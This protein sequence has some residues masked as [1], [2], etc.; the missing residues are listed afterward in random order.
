MLQGDDEVCSTQCDMYYAMVDTLTPVESLVVSMAINSKNYEDNFIKASNPLSETPTYENK[1]ESS[2]TS[3]NVN[4]LETDTLPSYQF[5]DIYQP[6]PVWQ[7]PLGYAAQGIEAFKVLCH[8]NCLK[9]PANIVVGDSGAV[10]M[11]ISEKFLKSLKW[12][13]PKT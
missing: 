10:P 12:S 2:W 5:E 13:T 11:L 4:I 3:L 8:V 1:D 9:E 6:I 7:R